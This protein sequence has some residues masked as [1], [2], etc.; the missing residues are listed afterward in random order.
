MAAKKKRLEMKAKKK[1]FKN[2]ENMKKYEQ[3]LPQ[4]AIWHK[5]TVP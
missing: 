2:Q 3:K 5:Q 1:P 4:S